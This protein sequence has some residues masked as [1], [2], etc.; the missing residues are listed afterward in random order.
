M[1]LQPATFSPLR[2]AAFRSIWGANFVSGIGTMVQGVG[3]A[4][5]MTLITDSVDLV[6][7]VQT[8]VSLP[9]LLFAILGG[10]IADSFDRRRSMIV[11]QGFMLA[12]S[13]AL[14]VLTYLGITNAWSLLAC[15]FLI[16][17]GNAIVNPSW[18]ATMGDLVPREELPAAVALNSLGFNLSRSVGP[19][20]GGA[21]VAIAGAGAA[22]ALNAVSFVA[23]IVALLRWKPATNVARMPR[24]TIAGAIFTGL[25]YVAM[26]PPV[27]IILARCFI[28]GSTVIA[29]LAL[30]PVV[31]QHLLGSDALTYGLLLGAYGAGAVGAAVFSSSIRKR[32]SPEALVR[33]AFIGFAVSTALSATSSIWLTAL[34][35]IAGGASW[36]LG[37]TLFN[38]SVQLSTPRWV[39]GRALSVYQTANFGG[40][41]LGSWVWGVLAEQ[42]G[43][44]QALLAASCALL[45][46]AALGL[47]M[48]LPAASDSDLSVLDSWKEPETAIDLL[49]R[50]GPIHIEVVFS[51]LPADAAEFLVLMNERRRI[52]RRDGAQ[53]WTLLRDLHDPNRWIERYRTPRWVDYV[54]HNLRRT[55]NDASVNERLRQLHQGPGEPLVRRFI[56]RSAAGHATTPPV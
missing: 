41:A 12:A 49:P 48:P 32:L 36:V 10:A 39:V 40:M 9:I 11:A 37:Q 1:S 25:R 47:L 51:I 19:A 34:G 56:E 3:A 54:R 17:C 20:F 15:T 35:L 22:F 2:H 43:I 29:V 50:S 6:A 14:A 44:Q 45:A 8:A 26:S 28:F 27:L 55:R 16:G 53:H 13:A 52:R 38:I 5:L 4:W 30:L 42:F 23:V 31:A 33:C 7:L 24:E 21:V 18:Q 46:G